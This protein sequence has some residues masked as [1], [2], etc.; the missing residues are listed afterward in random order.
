MFSMT[1]QSYLEGEIVN[2]EQKRTKGP[3]F[4][5]LIASLGCATLSCCLCSCFATLMV[6]I[7]DFQ[8]GFRE[9]YCE[10]VREEG[11]DP[12]ETGWCD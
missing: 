10:Q 4:W 1:D 6:T 7:E 2:Q 8:K 3:L 11:M 12:L 9:G 5:M